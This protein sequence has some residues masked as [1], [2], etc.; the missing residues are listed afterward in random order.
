MFSVLL[1]YE[2]HEIRE[3]FERTAR[4]RT[5]PL[6]ISIAADVSTADASGALAVDKSSGDQ[7]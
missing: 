6:E 1:H 7:S 2:R 3:D 5:L 4:D